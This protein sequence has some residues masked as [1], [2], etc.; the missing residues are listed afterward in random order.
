MSHDGL[1]DR[2]KMYEGV[3][4]TRLVPKMPVLVRL[5]G[6]AFH[7]FT[8]FME[9]PY[10]LRMQRCMWY[11]ARRLCE[12]IQ[13][14]QLAYV[15][16]DEIQLLLVDYHSVYSSPWFDY[17]VQK[18]VSVAAAICTAAFVRAYDREFPVNGAAAGCGFAECEPAFDARAWNIPKHEVV[19]AFIW[20]QQDAVRNSIQ[21]LAQAHFSHAR[22]QG[23]NSKQLQDL[24]FLEKG[25]NWN[26]CPVP[27]RRGV[28]V[29]R[30]P[31]TYTVIAGE[32][33]NLR[34][35][36][37]RTVWTVDE[38]IP[39]F[40]ENRSYIGQHAEFEPQD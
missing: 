39:I 27:Q 2:M 18:V 14:C 7:T 3:S 23:L 24:L 19:N 38:N 1:G 16:S 20:R 15:Q 9:K 17:E 5:D 22:L 26:D 31:E 33:H 25:V 34:V 40:T 35:P 36:S 37:E 30:Q 6:K 10:D 32:G 29:V 28:C 13:G 21:S 4:K 8:R 12:Q 11:A